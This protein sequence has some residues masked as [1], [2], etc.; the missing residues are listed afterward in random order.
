MSKIM[1]Y[2][3]V[4]L[5]LLSVGAILYISGYYGSNS[6]AK[7]DV[8]VDEIRWEKDYDSQSNHPYGSYF[9]HELID[10]GFEGYKLRNLNHSVADYFQHDS[11][12]VNAEVVNYFFIG[13]T[14]KLYND[15]V[16]SLLA[17]TERG[18]NIFIAAEFFPKSLLK[19]LI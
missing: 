6:Y 14:L 3:I 7:K 4:C 15:E 2:G 8:N 17:F 18:N 11:L 16:D 9:L 10:R 12:K 19:S 13:K 1:K 5:L